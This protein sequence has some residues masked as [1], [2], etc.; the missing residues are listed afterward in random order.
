MMKNLLGAAALL[1]ALAALPLFACPGQGCGPCGD[2]QGKARMM[3]PMDG[4]A[5][6]TAPR[7]GACG[8]GKGN[9]MDRDSFTGRVYR[10]LDN[11]ELPPEQWV[12]IGMAFADYR[13]DKLEHRES[14][15]MEGFGEKAFD[16]KAFTAAL[17]NHR[18]EGWAMKSALMEKIHRILTPAQRTEFA[19]MWKITPAGG[20]GYGMGYGACDGSGPGACR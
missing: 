2:G 17:E 11:M 7:W 12:K 3:A 8:T 9:A 18:Q 13:M 10:A 1:A 6:A 4:K 16:S 5:C 15:P 14:Q 19:R 20:Y